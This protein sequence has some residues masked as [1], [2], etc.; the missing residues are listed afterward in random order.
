GGGQAGS[1]SRTPRRRGAG[2]ASASSPFQKPET[3]S[4]NTPS[5]STAGGGGGDGMK[6]PARGSGVVRS[7][8]IESESY[9][10]RLGL[11]KNASEDAIKKAYRK[12]ALKYHPDK[13]KSDGAAHSFRLVSEAYRVLTSPDSKQQ[14]DRTRR[15]SIETPPSNGAAA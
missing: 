6:T 4:R 12:L 5:G 9:Y 1:A 11:P 3:W 2:A 10:R 15:Y 7:P 8:K 14:Y 13:N